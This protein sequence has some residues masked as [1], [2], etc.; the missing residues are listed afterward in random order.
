[1]KIVILAGGLGTRLRE[2]TE[3]KPKPMVNIG[4]MPILW[5][6]MQIYAQ[7]N[8]KDFIVCSGYKSEQIKDFFRNLRTLSSD[9]TINYGEKDEI[10][11][12]NKKDLLDWSV[13]VAD[14]GTMTLTSGRLFEIS[15]YLDGST[16]MCTYGDGL[17]DINITKLLEFH[18]SHG[19]IATITSIN[20]YSR[21]GQLNI[22]EDGA[23]TDFFE[24]PLTANWVNGGFF[25][26]EPEIFNYLSPTEAL[27]EK[28]FS[29]LISCSQ[30]MAFKHKGFWQSMDT[31]REVLFLNE[32][33]DT[34]KAPWKIWD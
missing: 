21:F 12:H 15:K 3:F 29:R 8:F 32:L 2:E 13:T 24:K 6:I 26:F 18:R 14:T 19:K 25:V 20:P 10:N 27:E 11:V 9:F 17:S 30:L 33:W 31:Y 22:S 23:V 5:H 16:F 34:G 4:T 28:T 1:M 7:F